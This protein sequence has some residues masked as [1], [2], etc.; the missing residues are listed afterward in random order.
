MSQATSLSLFALSERYLQAWQQHYQSLPIC[1]D[2]LAQLSSP[3]LV[4]LNGSAIPSY[5]QPVKIESTL[6]LFK[7]EQGVELTLHPD[8]HAFYGSQYSADMS[9]KWNHHSITLL[10][11]WNEEDFEGLQQNIIGHLLTQQRLKFKPS[12]FIAT[13]NSEWEVISICN[14]TG[15]VM[16]ENISNNKREILSENVALFLSQL[17]VEV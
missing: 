14:L 11:V 3:C 2:E 15:S 9:V 4:K 16:L 13:T 5:W 12:V 10:Q 6:T 8:I 17:I 7:V 1:N